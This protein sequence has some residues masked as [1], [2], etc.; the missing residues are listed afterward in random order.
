M[1]E[2]VNFQENGLGPFLIVVLEAEDQPGTI[3]PFLL[4]LPQQVLCR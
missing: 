1:Q 3:A 2:G 4:G